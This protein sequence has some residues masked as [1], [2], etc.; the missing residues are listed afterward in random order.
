MS[1]QELTFA[2]TQE[3]CLHLGLD[4]LS[5]DFGTLAERAA[6][7]KLGYADFLEQALRLEHEARSART[8][9]MLSK[10]A[11]F[12]VVKT[13]E[14]YDFEFATGAP[15]A[16]L[17]ELSSLAFVERADNVVLLG[18]SGVG[19]THLAIALGYRATQAG[20]KTRFISAADLI[21]QLSAAK[22]QGRLKDYL[23]RQIQTPKL[24]IID[25][26]GYLPFGRD[27]ANLFFQV[28]AKRYERSSVII[29]SNLPF[30]QWDTAFAGDAT[31]TA[32]M[33]DRLL[34]HAHVAMITGDSY[35]LKE[36]RKAGIGLPNIPD[37]TVGQN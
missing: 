37:I 9:A 31:L 29:T 21:L 1:R 25:E 14:E 7:D 2:K 23:Q 3:L 18:P 11:G 32:A 30:T 5:R 8:R 26:I 10:L 13:L 17:T 6:K 12:P 24:L 28:V 4:T 22:R 27:E 35:R 34:H 19:K 20:V 16:L 36:R 15:K 33:L